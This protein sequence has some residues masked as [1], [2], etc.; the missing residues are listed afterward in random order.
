MKIII[1]FLIFLTIAFSQINP[2]IKAT[3]YLGAGFDTKKAVFGLAPIFKL[4][5]DGKK[6][7]T[8]PHSKIKYSVPDEMIVS[9]FDMV[10]EIVFQGKYSSYY[11]YLETYS[12]WFNFDIGIDTGKFSG[13]FQYN[14]ALGSVY[15]YMSQGITDALHGNHVWYFFVGTMYPPN[16]LDLDIM[17]KKTIDK[18]PDEIK[19]QDDLVEYQNCINT[20]GTHYLYKSIFGARIDFNAF[21]K[22]TFVEQ[23]SSEWISEQFGFYFHYKL[24]NVSAGGFY[25]QSEISISDKFLAE[26]NADTNF[27]GG[28][29]S[30]SNLDNLTDWRNTIDQFVFPLNTTL[31][32]LWSLISNPIKQQT[33]KNYIMSYISGK[34]L[35]NKFDNNVECLG[36]G[37]DMIS[38][39]PCLAPIFDVDYKNINI[40]NTPDSYFLNINVTMTDHFN[41]E[42]WSK[43]F[44]TS[45]YGFLGLGKKSKEVY[46]FYSNLLDHK[47]S[48]V[49][50]WVLI[51]YETITYPIMPRP[52]LNEL[53]IKNLNLL[54]N[55]DPLNETIIN[56]YH[57]FFQ[58][59]GNAFID[60]IVIGGSF[61]FNILYDEAFISSH[62]IEW[63]KENA[64]WSFIG[65]IGDG[66]GK[67]YSYESVDNDFKYSLLS[68]Y[69]Y[70]GGDTV[71]FGPNMW[72]NWLDTIYNRKAIIKYNSWPIT[73]I[74][75]DERIKR[76]IQMALDDYVKKADDDLQK[77]IKRKN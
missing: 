65:I 45:S 3:Q 10:H 4:N 64:H 6:E 77:F 15:K 28:D 57:T 24:F 41:G 61:R 55:Y 39:T 12:S 58:T 67:S 13:G 33:M 2:P 42:A 75:S 5:Y 26:T 69:E 49:S 70:M 68:E 51:S 9:D 7:W 32:G 16:I 21:A 63:V 27:F 59:F 60:Q 23:Y 44:Y 38:L 76:N 50:N 25:N 71:S 74:I 19:N 8:S 17:F 72:K 53:F 37:F 34:S 29:P 48:L 66:H 31:S 47:K 62:S 14:E 54:N 52:K 46:E 35:K 36:S 43:Y 11:E 22:K 18:L 56:E 73:K 40:Q 20:F 30:L 1:L